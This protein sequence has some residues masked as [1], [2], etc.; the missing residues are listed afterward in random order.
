MLTYVNIILTFKLLFNTKGVC[1]KMKKILS[2]LLCIAMIVSAFCVNGFAEADKVC[3]C[4]GECEFYP[5]IIIPGLGQSGVFVA[6]EEGKPLLDDEGKRISAFPAY[7]QIG[8]VIK[9]ALFPV[10]LSLITQSDFGLSNA[11]ANV[12]ED[13]FGI[14]SSDL[15][16]QNTGNVI[17]EKYNF[18]FFLCYV[19]C[20]KSGIFMKET[21][22]YSTHIQQGKFNV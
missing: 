16:A 14:N 9:E 15:N 18:F 7:I 13:A 1:K 2:I 3:D 17:L 22:K 8:N 10:L 4:N 12:I 5:T 11:L 21:T 19:F 20:G 6:D